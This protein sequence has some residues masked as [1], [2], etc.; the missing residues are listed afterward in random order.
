MPDEVVCFITSMRKLLKQGKFR[1]SDREYSDGRTYIQVLVDDFGIT[2]EQAWKI[3]SQLSK[4]DNVEDRKPDYR[5]DGPGYVF[6]KVVNDVL[7]YIKLKI[8][9]VENDDYIVCIAFHKDH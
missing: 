8:E 1:F 2:P 7:A 3:I 6:K 5:K 9:E 4:Y